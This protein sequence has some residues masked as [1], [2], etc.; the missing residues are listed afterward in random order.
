MI[1]NSLKHLAAGGICCCGC[2]E[3]PATIIPL[4]TTGGVKIMQNPPMKEGDKIN[5]Y[6]PING[7][8]EEVGP[9][10]VNGFA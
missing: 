1:G 8:E 9:P 7:E 5:I 4:E 10:V 2:F 6:N 3:P